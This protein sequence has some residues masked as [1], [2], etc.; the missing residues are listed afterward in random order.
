MV[1]WGEAVLP[2]RPALRPAGYARTG[3]TGYAASVP[4]CLTRHQ[5]EEAEMAMTTQAF[6]RQLSAEIKEICSDNGWDP[7]SAQSRGAAFERWCA[8]RFAAFEFPS[9]TDPEDAVVG[10]PR[11]LG[12]DLVIYDDAS[13]RVLICQCKF[14]GGSARQPGEEVTDFFS[15]HGR[16]QQPGWLA[17]HGSERLVEMLPNADEFVNSPERFTYRF[18]T[19]AKVQP[20]V[21]DAVRQQSLQEGPTIDLWD[22]ERLKKFYLE[23]ESLDQPIADEVKF[24]LPHDKFIEISEPYPGIVAVIKTNT[25]RNLWSTHGPRLYAYNIRG[26]LGNKGLN[27]QI[28]ETLDAQPENFLYYNNGISAVCTDYKIVDGMLTASS[29]QII[30]GAQ[31]INAIRRAHH[32]DSDAHVLF[33]LT[34]TR[35]VKTESGINADIIRYNNSQNVVKDSDFRSNDPIQVWL[36]SQFKTKRWRWTALP[37][38][39]YVRKRAV[40]R[41]KGQG[42]ALRLEEFAKIL[43]SWRYEP[44]LVVGKPRALFADAESEGKYE[45]TFGV[46]G[47]LPSIWTNTV[48]EDGLLGLWFYYRIELALE[49]VRQS[50]A[51]RYAWVKGHRWHLLGLARLFV[52]ERA[53]QPRHVLRDESKGEALFNEFFKRAFPLIDA[54]ETRRV[55]ANENSLRNWRTSP[56]EWAKLCREFEGATQTSKAVLAA[57]N[58]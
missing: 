19:T 28:I 4:R 30:N 16:L 11:D 44:T 47:S 18:I 52:Q 49:R 45:A 9:A 3:V 57:L 5:C 51:D 8:N 37:R 15:L 33:R 50:D 32:M 53:V 21:V 55:E 35:S 12:I 40:G 58:S 26:Y 7:E 36:E 24:H 13:D 41:P 56:S 29:L 46:D 2:R 54:A 25:L 38:I 34:K 6:R 43:Y 23:A 22:T 42:R 39:N 10:G 27:K 14:R 48:F 31:T 20:R 1:A 17:E